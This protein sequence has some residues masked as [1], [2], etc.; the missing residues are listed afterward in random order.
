MARQTTPLT[1]KEIKAAKPR[2][3]TYRLFDGGGLRLEISP[4]GQKWWRFK[5]RFSGRDKL[6]SLGVYP[7]TS[8]QAARRQRE[9]LKE[10]IA[11]GI[12]PSQQRK[13]AKAKAKAEK[14]KSEKTLKVVSDE[15]FK[16]LQSKE[17]KLSEKY[18]ER[19]KQ[20][21]ANY[22]HTDEAARKPIDEVKR[23]DVLRIIES[24]VAAK[25]YEVAR[26][27][28]ISLKSILEFA[29]DHE[30]VEINV[31]A[32]IKPSK[33]IGKRAHKHHPVITDPKE[34]KGLLLALDE[35]SGD[36]STKQALRM[37][38]YVALR[39]ANIRFLEWS[40]VDLDERVISIPAS[41]MKTRE[42][43]RIPLT[44]SVISILEEIQPYSGEGKYVFP[45]RIHKD[46]P[47]SENTLNLGLR[48]LGYT[49]EQ[50][51][52]HS[53]RGIFSTIAHSNMKKH[54]FGSLI[55]EAQ[56]GHKDTNE[57]RESY[58][59]ND[60]FD[61]RVELMQWWADWLDEVRK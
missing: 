54:G 47:V 16:H 50:I 34:L 60:Y 37:M 18:F 23:S 29:A 21:I 27:V 32:G 22:V 36:F 20:R 33:A 38:P 39:P 45:S 59:H 40:E 7:H 57:S 44:S 31:A 12:D 48:R 43:H 1:D 49:N 26:R 52:S 6:I 8:L 13:D 51:V 55:I 3:K 35:Y 17:D 53:F 9:Q 14:L 10:H 4:K 24:L 2:E 30:Y 28:L 61:D 11:Q 46:R 41:K 25:N 42:D 19:L 56:L 58:N 5:Y 15:Y